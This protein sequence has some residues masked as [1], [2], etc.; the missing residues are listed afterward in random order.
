[1]YHNSRKMAPVVSA[2]LSRNTLGTVT[3]Q[4]YRVVYN[5]SLYPLKYEADFILSLSGGVRPSGTDT[6]T[7]THTQRKRK[8]VRPGRSGVEDDSLE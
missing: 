4:K 7:H 3:K 8:Y 6:H 2:L 1:M 5:M